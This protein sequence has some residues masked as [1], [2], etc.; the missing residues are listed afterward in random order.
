[1][2]YPHSNNHSMIRLTI[3]RHLRGLLLLIAAFTLGNS[4][5]AI[6]QKANTENPPAL[7]ILT[8]DK[9]IDEMVAKLSL[10]QKVGQ[11]T[12]IDLGV[13][14][15]GS[16]CGLQQPQTLDK[17]KLREAIE[18]YHIGSVLNVG[19][20]SGTIALDRWRDIHRGI[21]QAEAEFSS[22]HIPILFGI[23]AIHGV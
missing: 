15:V 4:Q 11:M 16:P 12:Q 1:M 7:S 13:I 9:A 17:T 6:A 2:R 8:L 20:G 14:A 10:E 21:A 18:K 23:D 5:K 3:H 19:C 22:S